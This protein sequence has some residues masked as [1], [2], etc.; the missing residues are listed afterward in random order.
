MAIRNAGES[1]YMKVIPLIK[2]T[3]KRK[4]KC[5]EIPHYAYTWP[6]NKTTLLLTH[7]VLFFSVLHLFYA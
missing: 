5:V 3:V 4:R 6:L 1:A 7:K 2:L